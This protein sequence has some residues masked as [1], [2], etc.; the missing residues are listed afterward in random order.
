MR[1]ELRGW[2]HVYFGNVAITDCFVSAVALRRASERSPTDETTS[3]AE[4]A[5]FGGKTGSRSVHVCGRARSIESPSYSG[6]PLTWTS[7]ELPS[8]SFRPCQQGGDGPPPTAPAG[9]HFP[10]AGGTHR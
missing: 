5:P 9:A 10:P 3:P 6:A 2:G 4:E 7:S 8:R 1:D